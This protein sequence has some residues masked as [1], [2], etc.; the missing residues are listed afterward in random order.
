NSG[1]R[2]LAQLPKLGQKVIKPQAEP[3]KEAQARP[4]E[5]ADWYQPRDHVVVTSVAIH[6]EEVAAPKELDL[7]GYKID[8]KAK[9]G[10]FKDS[11]AKNYSLSK[12][13]N[14][15]V[16]RFAELK[17]A[18]YGYLL[19][20]L[21]CSTE[22]LRQLQKKALEGSIK[23]NKQLFAENEYNSELLAIIGGGGKKK[24]R[25]QQKIIGEVRTQLIAQAKNLGLDDHYTTRRIVEIQ[26][27][28]C[29]K[30][31]NKFR[32]EKNGLE[33]QLKYYGVN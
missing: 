26:I 32:E 29:Q 7:Y 24:A 13:H 17:T 16:A 30:I 9:V 22:D 19:S 27:E 6:A 2:D 21:G 28:Q 10:G 4:K 18:F 11:Y 15:M 33:Y 5:K 8:L 14:L 20:M 12:S 25:A 31:V 23:Q 1:G 3:A